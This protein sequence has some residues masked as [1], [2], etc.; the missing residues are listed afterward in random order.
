MTLWFV[1]TCACHIATTFFS[2]WPDVFG[3]DKRLVASRRGLP[4]RERGPDKAGASALIKG[5][6]LVVSK[7]GL[8]FTP[9]PHNDGA[10]HRVSARIE[11]RFQSW[12]RLLLA[13]LLACPL[14]ARGGSDP[15]GSSACTQPSAASDVLTWGG[16]LVLRLIQAARRTS[17]QRQFARRWSHRV[18][19]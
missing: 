7:I 8:G 17:T 16:T 4:P 15:R 18:E 12:S 5:K 13:D 14:R 1:K 3:L 2:T 11:S 10:G 19:S 6:S 9:L